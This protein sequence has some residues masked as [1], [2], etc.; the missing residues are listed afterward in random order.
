MTPRTRNRGAHAGAHRAPRSRPSPAVPESGQPEPGQAGSGQ[1]EASQPEAGQAGAGQARAGQAGSGQ[2]ETVPPGAAPPGPGHPAPARPAPVPGIRARGARNG[3]RHTGGSMLTRLPRAAVGKIVAAVVI[4]GVIAFGLVRGG[5]PSAEPTVQAFLLAW[6]NGQYKTAAALTTGQPPAVAAALSDAYTQLDAAGLVLEMKHIS[7]HGASATAAFRATV[8]L[9]T[10]GL[11]WSYQGSFTMRATGSGWRILWSPSVIVPGLGPGDRLAVLTTMPG[12]AQIE[13][14]TGRPLG[15]P[16]PVYAVGVRPGSLRDPQQTAAG[17]AAVTGLDENQIYGQIVAAPSGPFLPLLQ[18]PPATYAAWQRKLR[19]IPGVIIE[20]RFERLFDSIVPAVT[21]SVG[22]E[23]A[24]VLQQDGVPYRPGA[25]VGLSGLQLAYQRTLTGSPTTEVVLQDAGGRQLKVLRRWDGVQGAPVQTTISSRVQLAADAAVA[26][27]PGSAAIVAVQPGTGKILAVGAHQV[28]GM[29]AID[30]LAGQYQ[31][32]QSF[33]IISTAALLQSGFSVSSRIP[34]RAV[35]S[36]G[37]QSFSNQ[38][39]EADLGAQPPFTVDFAHACGTAFVGLS[40]Q[41]NARDL[42][43]AASA[44]GIGASWQLKIPATSGTIGRPSGYGPVAAASVGSG[45]V[46]VSPLDMA[47]AAAVVQSGAWYPPV[48]VTS[49]TDP[50]LRPRREFT[51]Q[52]VASLRGLMRAT[53]TTGAGQAA[54]VPG[55]AVFGQVGSTPAGTVG[56]GLGSAWFVGYQGGIAFA[57]IE[58]TR[59]PEAS[60]AALAGTF[61]RD[62]RG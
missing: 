27:A 10:S 47:L 57:V 11:S 6:E 48:L 46:R 37:G 20:R 32:G 7:Q 15:V 28:R 22:T 54:S 17:L 3:D 53:V 4:V 23:T 21:G 43:S 52:V 51:P 1:P 26:R 45:G 50:G 16:S 60:A 42:A 9:G 29:P 62:I 55:P 34:C 8:D 36:V 59:S 39:V 2:P 12:R 61:L 5:T 38:P 58:Y 25:T 30:P 41:L 56:K 49:P 33:T 35:N 40:L 18:L 13:D 19:R 44:F 24:P 14:D 31:P